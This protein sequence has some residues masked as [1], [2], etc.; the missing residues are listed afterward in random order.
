MQREPHMLLGSLRF[1]TAYLVAI[2]SLT[3][4]YEIITSPQPMSGMDE[5]SLESILAKYERLRPAEDPK[6]SED[7]RTKHHLLPPAGFAPTNAEINAKLEI[8]TLT[9]KNLH[10]AVIP[11]FLN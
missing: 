2:R 8:L 7:G 11:F 5:N 4:Y 10:A 9:V 3:K 1:V 6:P